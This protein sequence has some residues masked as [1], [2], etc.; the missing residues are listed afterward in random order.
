MSQPTPYSRQYSFTAYQASNPT[1]P[2]PG[3]KID[4]ELNAAKTTFDEILTNLALI[5]RDDGKL[6]NG[7]VGKAQ[8]DGSLITLGFERPDSWATATAYDVD[9]AIFI[10]NKLY[11]C[12]VAHTSGVF[13]TDLAALKWVLVVDYTTLVTD[14]QAAATA[15]AVSAAAALGSQNAAATSASE[16]NTSA[17]TALSYLNAITS[18]LYDWYGTATGT[19]NYSVAANIYTPAALADGFQVE[20]RVGNANVGAPTLVV[21]AYAVKNVVNYDGSAI[22]AGEWAAN[23]VVTLTYSSTSGQF[24]WKG[25]ANTVRLAAKASANTFSAA[26]TF[27]AAANMDGDFASI[28]GPTVEPGGRLTLTSGVPVLTS[29]VTAATTVYYTPYK[30]NMIAVPDGT[31]W[32]RK[33]FTELSQALSDATKS[34][35][36]A[37]V[38]SNYDMFVWDDAGTLRLSRGPAWSSLTARGTGAGTTELDTLHGV[39]INKVAITNGPAAGRG[40]YVGT[41]S[42]SAT[43]ANGQLNMMFAPAAALGGSNNRLDV[44]NA[45]NRVQMTSAVRDSTDTWNYASATLRAKNNSNLNRLTFVRGLDEDSVSAVAAITT[46]SANTSVGQVAIGLDSTSAFASGC[47]TGLCNMSTGSATFY[48]SAVSHYAG[49]PGIGSHFLQELEASNFAAASIAFKGDNGTPALLQSGM[50]ILAMM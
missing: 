1:E 30:H 45:F 2:L 40:V 46:G 17:T 8:L 31:R 14:A 22:L 4:I 20:F 39:E 24:L 49:L 10:N 25:N 36:A 23:A 37:A 9:D 32:V 3:Q 7:S 33:F 18:G 27:T 5:Q 15:A 43:G 38:S 12:L 19:T 50:N 28:G 44:W 26:N 29:D 11:F 34:P 21:G 48:S 16:A 6:A 13:N 42:T 47:V 41:I 35:S